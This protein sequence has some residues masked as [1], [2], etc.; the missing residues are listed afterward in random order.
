MLDLSSLGIAQKTKMAVTIKDVAKKAGVNASTVSRVI[1]D[2]SEISDK[3]KAK[4]RKAMQ[5][6]G[7]RRNAAAQILASGKTNT[8]G[9]V[10][11]PVSD[12]ASQPFFMKILT[13]INETAR[14]Y[15]VS[16]AIATGHSTK[17][18]KKQVE[19]Q[20]SEKRVDG[21]IILYAGKRD[22]IRDY[23]L[24][25]DIPFVLVGTPSERQNEITHVDNDNMLLGREAVRHLAELQHQKI[26]FVTD[27]TEG[28]VYEER[29]Q[30][31]KD[32]MNRL[33][34]TKRLIFFNKDFMLEDETALVVM[35]DVLALKVVERLSEIGLKVPD[36][37]SMITYNNSIFASILHPYLTTFDIHIEQLGAAAVKKFLDL[38]NDKN[39]LPEKTIIPFELILRESTKI[40]K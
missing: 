24:E 12:K 38:S 14:D 34:L 23:L 32:E 1:K 16:V 2:S 15:N 17:E 26:A 4:V 30:G 21:F 13:S 31:F 19:L 3:T 8:I 35:D 39:F 7:Y 5:D 33:G 27:T 28:E 36:D 20:Y 40:K 22:E 37:V 29:Y 11:P 25:N 6:L 10:F 18:L 9:V